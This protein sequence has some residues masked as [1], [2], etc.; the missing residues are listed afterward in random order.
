MWGYGAAN[1]ARP[2]R[3]PVNLAESRA[4]PYFR[5]YSSPLARYPSLISLVSS[6]LEELLWEHNRNDSA[7]NKLRLS[8]LSLSGEKWEI[9]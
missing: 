2:V 5:G 6:R 9:G 7:R 4:Q 8:L 1:A 3:V